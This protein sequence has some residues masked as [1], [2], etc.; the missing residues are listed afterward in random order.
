[1]AEAISEITQD[2]YDSGNIEIH[3]CHLKHDNGVINLSGGLYEFVVHYGITHHSASC[4]VTVLDTQDILADLDID[5][6]ETIKLSWSSKNDDVITNEFTIYRKHTIIDTTQAGKGKAYTLHGIDT[7]NLSQ[8]TMD[9][10]RSFSGKV[11]DHVKNIFNQIETDKEIEVHETTGTSNII[12][13]GET[14]FQAIN[15]LI[16][17]AFSTTYTSSLFRFFQSSKGYNFKNLE[18]IIA[19]KRDK[20]HLYRYTPTALAEDPKTISAKHSIISID[21]PVKKS[22]INKLQ[23]GTYA[24]RVAEIDIINQKLDITDFNVKES[25]D[26]FYHLDRP[27]ISSDKKTIIDNALNIINTTKWINKYFDGERH[28]DFRRGPKIVRNKFYAGSLDE[29]EMACVIHG[30]SSIDCGEIFHLA[31][32]ERS[33]R[34][35]VPEDEKIISGNYLISNVTHIYKNGTY[36]CNLICNK[37]S[38]RANV[39]D[40]D[41][42]L[43]GDRE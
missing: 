17:L 11:S 34:S 36:A 32:L 9:I 33:G 13:P 18:R 31:M 16:K 30:N 12:V 20:P 27:A 19:E 42:Y 37:E 8:M 39:T 29:N 6:S 15:R 38:G 35:N 24:S 14:P 23:R 22:L 10:N 5:G 4:K 43:I 25:F 26:N 3:A 1:M 28:L 40:L 7:A 21:F 41:N 2:L